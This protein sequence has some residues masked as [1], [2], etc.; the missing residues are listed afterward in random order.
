[1]GKKKVVSGLRPAA[2]RVEGYNEGL[3]VY[4]YDAANREAII[5]DGLPGLVDAHFAD[6]EAAARRRRGGAYP[7]LAYELRQDDPIC[8]DIVIGPPLSRDERKVPKG[9]KCLAPQTA[10]LDLPSG[11]LCVESA[12]S[13]RLNPEEPPVEPPGEVKIPPGTYVVNLYRIEPEPDG[14]EIEWPEALPHEIVVF[15]PAEDVA[16]P[17]RPALVLRHLATVRKKDVAAC[18]I[19]DGGFEGLAV[20][21]EHWDFFA[22]NLDAEALNRLGL[23]YGS[24]MEVT[25]GRKKFLV[26]CLEGGPKLKPVDLAAGGQLIDLN[27]LPPPL[28]EN[29]EIAV[30]I[31]NEIGFAERPVLWCVR[32]KATDAA[33]RLNKWIKASGRVLPG[34]LEVADESVFERWGMAGGAL[35]GEV[36]A[37]KPRELFLNI[38]PDALRK[39]GAEQD[40]VLRIRIGDASLCARFVADSSALA[41]VLHEASPFS[42]EDR[43]EKWASLIRRYYARDDAGKA[44]VREKI[45]A[46]LTPDP[47]NVALPVDHWVFPDRKVLLVQP[48][49]GD[50]DSFGVE[51]DIGVECGPGDK[52]TIEPA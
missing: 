29:P 43:G 7:L 30:G 5:R 39:I 47:P 9:L 49:A 46:F 16:R 41:D 32:I 35:H 2:A 34:Q 44:M 1:M 51:F 22:L 31:L 15:T 13:S 18:E 48:I 26:V 27:Q 37:R 40:S 19:R 23:K 38:P 4:L 17:P 14:E 36:V 50:W 6:P 10:M 52:V 24:I 11:T 28:A 42:T 8:V 20:F 21:W 25:I 12:N 45:R 3:V 33:K